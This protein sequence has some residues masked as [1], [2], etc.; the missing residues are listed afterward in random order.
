MTGCNTV[1][2]TLR[3]CQTTNA[4]SL[5]RSSRSLA[6]SGSTSITR[7]RAVHSLSAAMGSTEAALV[8]G[9]KLARSA[10]A[11]STRATVVIR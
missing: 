5:A 10:A 1:S 6:M 9:R 11:A 7:R 4:S 2:A 3:L 8:A